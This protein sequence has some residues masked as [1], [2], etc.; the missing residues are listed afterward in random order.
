MRIYIDSA[1]FSVNHY[2]NPY[3][4]INMYATIVEG[5]RW[6]K[7]DACGFYWDTSIKYRE[8]K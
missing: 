6:K 4:G 2:V 3:E 7:R 8:A 5:G 1:Q